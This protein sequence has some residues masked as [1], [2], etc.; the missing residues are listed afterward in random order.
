MQTQASDKDGIAMTREAKSMQH[1][2]YL[3]NSVDYKFLLMQ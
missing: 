1:H 2:F 3:T